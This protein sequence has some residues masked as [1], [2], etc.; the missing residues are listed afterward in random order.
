MKYKYPRT[1][2]LPWTEHM[3]TDDKIMS[4]EEVVRAFTDYDF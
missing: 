1:L 3:T 4:H 2:H